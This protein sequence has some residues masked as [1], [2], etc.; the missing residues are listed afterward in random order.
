MKKHILLWILSLCILSAAQAAP[1]SIPGRSQTAS[2]VNEDMVLLEDFI[3]ATQ[4]TLQASMELK[5]RVTH[6]LQVQEKYLADP[7]NRDV[8]Y[9]M[10]K[11]A[12]GI[13]DEIEKNHLSQLFTNQ[14][15]GEVSFFAQLGK[16]K[17]VPQL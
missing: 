11:E 5:E 7:S 2:E 13:M 10:V 4:E 1:R 8:A 14:F 12:R 6:Y 15:L 16:K 17:G 9:R 3:A